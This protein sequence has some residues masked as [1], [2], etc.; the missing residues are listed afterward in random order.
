MKYKRPTIAIA[1][2]AVT[3]LSVAGITTTAQA[4]TSDVNVDWKI[5]QDWGSGFQG[6]VTV[7]NTSTKSINP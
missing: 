2:L 5:T 6:S 7:K 3:A 1:A 4:A